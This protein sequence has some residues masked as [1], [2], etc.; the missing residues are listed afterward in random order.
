MKKR[1][2]TDISSDMYD[3]IVVKR[4]FEDCLRSQ[5]RLRRI[6]RILIS[7]NRPLESEEEREYFL[8]ELGHATYGLGAKMPFKIFNPYVIDLDSIESAARIICDQDSNPVV[9]SCPGV[10]DSPP[11]EIKLLWQQLLNSLYTIFPLALDRASAMS[12]ELDASITGEGYDF[13]PT[14]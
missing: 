8:S 4:T 1:K 2:K 12:K 10:K 3:S 14:R 5:I 9:I 11:I 13:N 7:D 6:L